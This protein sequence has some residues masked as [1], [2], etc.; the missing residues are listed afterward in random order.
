MGSLLQPAMTPAT[1]QE[2]TMLSLCYWPYTIPFS[3]SITR[4]VIGD[5][6]QASAYNGSLSI[7]YDYIG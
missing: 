5:S 2:I 7:I 1:G 6:Q 4:Q 3:W